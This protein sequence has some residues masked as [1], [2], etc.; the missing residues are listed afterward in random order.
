MSSD[1][2]YLGE[3]DRFRFPDPEKAT[4]E[5]IV[6]AG[7]NLSPGMLLSAYSQGIFP[8]FSEHDPILWW[9]PDP[10]F[11][12]FPEKLHVSKTM[13]KFLRRT[14]LAFT[15]D[16]AFS[17]VIR[18]C[19]RV[20]RD[21]QDGTWITTEMEA[22]YAEMHTLGYAHSV[23]V[24]S[25]ADLVGGLYGVS[26]GNIFF[27]ESMFSHVSNASKAAFI[28]FVRRLTDL[29]F[30]LIDSQVYTNHLE[31]LGAEE[32]PRSRYLELLRRGLT[33]PTLKGSW[34]GLLD[35]DEQWAPIPVTIGAQP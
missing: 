12:L 32:I 16:T 11:V 20:P 27:G 34:R 22:A 19:A 7:G 9:S 26:L 31:R 28:R 21:G 25:G 8:W 10:R 5:G 2:P 14:D 23:E 33:R 4:L 15:A 3:E 1:F 35:S 18:A 17:E 24:W 30:D 6:A 13:R 29:G